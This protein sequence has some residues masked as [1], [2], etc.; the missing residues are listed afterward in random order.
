MI[1]TMTMAIMTIMTMTMIMNYD[2]GDDLTMMITAR[3]MI[4]IL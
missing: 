2:D 3:Y 1:R 4:T